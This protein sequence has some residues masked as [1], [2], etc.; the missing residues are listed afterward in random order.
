MRYDHSNMF[1]P[2][3]IDEL[4][5]NS[6]YIVVGNPDFVEV[7][8]KSVL[9]ADAKGA[10]PVFVMP[11]FQPNC[12]TDLY[13]NLGYPTFEARYP[14]KFES[15]ESLASDLVKVRFYSLRKVT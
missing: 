8:T 10:Y 7:T 4:E 12:M 15:V 11:G 13:N 14:S 9:Y 3:T 6:K 5:H 2:S 1:L